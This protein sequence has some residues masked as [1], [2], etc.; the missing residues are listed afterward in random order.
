[1]DKTPIQ[2]SIDDIRFLEDRCEDP[3]AKIAYGMAVKVIEFHLGSEKKFAEEMFNAGYKR[4]ED[5]KNVVDKVEGQ[6]FQDFKTL[7]SKYEK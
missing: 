5:Q 7:Y 3:L 2:E 1:M 4:G 6:V